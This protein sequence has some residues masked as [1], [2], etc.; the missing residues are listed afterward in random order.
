MQLFLWDVTIRPKILKSESI[1]SGWGRSPIREAQR[2]F[3][4]LNS[5]RRI[6]SAHKCNKNTQIL[7]DLESAVMFHVNEG[8][9]EVKADYL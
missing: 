8:L 3:T 4:N 1:L 2:K 6:R 5:A 7:S 9:N